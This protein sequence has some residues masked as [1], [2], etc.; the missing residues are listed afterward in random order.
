MF[1]PT[2]V[3]SRRSHKAL[4]GGTH[5]RVSRSTDEIYTDIEVNVNSNV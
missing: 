2:R 3:F 4:R 5:L 1:W